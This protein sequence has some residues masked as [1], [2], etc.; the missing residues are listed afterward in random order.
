MWGG[1]IRTYVGGA[2]FHAVASGGT[3]CQPK[4][5]LVGF[6]SDPKFL[7]GCVTDLRSLSSV[8]VL[9]LQLTY[10]PTSHVCIVSY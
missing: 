4:F 7:H 5:K 9:Y 10:I 3:L 6:L 8:I 2:L 1:Y